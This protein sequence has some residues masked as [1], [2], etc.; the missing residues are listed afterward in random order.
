MEAI[1][2]RSIDERLEEWAEFNRAF[3]RAEADGIRR[4]HPNYDDRQVFLALVRHRYGDDLVRS[5]WP[6]DELV[7]P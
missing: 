1:A 7:D 3:A 2:A 4:R 5:A 6:E